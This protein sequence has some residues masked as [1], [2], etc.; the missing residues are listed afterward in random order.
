MSCEHDCQKPPVFPKTIFNRPGLPRIDYR[1]GTYAEMR[2]HMFDLLNKEPMLAAWTHRGPDDPGIAL[3]EGA[4]IA[5]DI[6]TFYQQLYANELYLRT[7]Q[8]RDSVAELV[9]LLGYRL[10][11]GLGG[12]ATFALAVKGDRAVTVPKGFGLKAQLEGQEKPADFESVEE[13]VVY[14][15]LSQFNLF[16]PMHT[17]YIT[18]ATKEFYIFSPDQFTSPAQI[19]KGDRLFIGDPYPA[20]NPTRLINGEIIVIDDVRE[21]HG[22]KLYK[23]KGS[24][25][26]AGSVFEVAGFKLGR[27]FRHF[28][29]NAP[30]KTVSIASDGTASESPVSFI[31]DLDLDAPGVSVGLDAAKAFPLDTKVED[32]PTGATLIVQSVLR[33]QSGGVTYYSVVT[34]ALIRTIQEIRQISYSWGPLTGGSTLVILNEKL[35]TTTNPAV[36]TFYSSSLGALTFDRLDIREAEFHEARSPLLRLRA[37]YQETAAVSGNELY[38]Y[39]TDA[40]VQA[41]SDQKL[42][43]AK[44]GEETRSVAV[45][46]VQTL[47]P[48]FADRPLLRRAT[49]DTEVTYADFPNENPVVTVYG[50]LISATQGKTQAEVVLGSGDRRQI[51]QTLA[52]PKAPLTYL[53]D[54]TQTPAQVPELRV[55]VEGI[56]WRRVDSFFNCLP[57]DAVYIVREDEDDKSYVQFGDGKTGRRLPSGLNNVTAVYRVGQG[58]YGELK[59]GTNPSATG[60]LTNFAKLFLPAPATGGCGHEDGDNARVA[61]PGKMQSLG[62]IVSLAD[63]QAEAL[64]I[65]HV[66]KARAAWSAPEGVP[67]VRLTV[68]TESG[69]TAD[70]QAVSDSMRTFNRCRGPARYPI[71]VVQGIRQ[72]AYLKLEVG[73]DAARREKD[74]KAAIKTALGL[75]GEEGNGIDGSE[76]LFGLKQREFGQGAHSSQIVAAVQNAT[77]VTWVKLLAAENLDLGTPPETDPTQLAKPS[78][79]VVNAVLACAEDRLLALHTAHFTLSLSKDEVAKECEA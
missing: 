63:V 66:I 64:A 58:A 33:F 37:G 34:F 74:V 46:A 30:S 77:G 57:D 32:F 14:P 5:G 6:L 61:A 1:I 54:V 73:F 28:G 7:S 53:L 2:E 15:W 49:L 4:A 56:E 3:I 78:V 25:K 69:S 70:L 35:T 40:Q 38:F 67:L 55:S 43:L 44:E 13:K 60:K 45:Q 19:Q 39:G 8:W 9:R 52:L 20:T 18:N 23:I 36:D 47:S 24:L 79:D 21:L 26:R 62:R 50:N 65:P 42:F 48:S 31:R 41:L 16:R 71:D 68:L 59:S 10:A 75:A 29:H 76:G 27:S 12:E 22:T 17:P 51:F 72:Y 11:P